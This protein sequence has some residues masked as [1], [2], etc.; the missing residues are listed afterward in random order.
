MN[1]H[2]DLGL[3]HDPPQEPPQHKRV[4]PS[5]LRFSASRAQARAE[6]AV[7]AV[8]ATADEDAAEKETNAMST[9]APT[10]TEVAVQVV[11]QV[12]EAT[13]Q[14][15]DLQSLKEKILV[16]QTNILMVLLAQL[17]NKQR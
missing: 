9:P 15:A 2:I 3:P 10:L 8:Q 7:D 17:T 6:A 14:V 11:P 16:C 13:V 12:L 5:R 4:G 1:L